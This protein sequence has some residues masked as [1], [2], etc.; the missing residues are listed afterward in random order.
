MR[1]RRELADDTRETMA[2]G[3][4]Y[5]PQLRQLVVDAG[6]PAGLA[7]LPAVESGFEPRARGRHGELGLWQL[8]P[9][10]AR[11]FGL[12]VNS[13]RDDR[14]DP[15]RSTRAAVR[16]LRFLTPTCLSYGSP[17]TS[18][19]LA[20]V[21]ELLAAVREEMPEGKIY[22]GTF[23]SECRPEHVTRESLRVL[24]KY[25][26][27]RTLVIGGQ[28]GSERTL[29]ET[30]RGHGVAEII[31]AVRLSVEAGF[32]PN[33][34]LLLG[35]PGE[36]AEDR[37]LSLQLARK[38][39]GL[40]ARIHSHAFMPLPGTPLRGATPAEIEPA[41]LREMERMESAG[42]MYGQWRR[43][44]QVAQQLVTLRAAPR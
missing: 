1:T 8:R 31:E 29:R 18:V 37:A 2:R 36:T 9:A 30:H 38:L 42:A 22:F 27:N 12:V 35:L 13:Q 39:I 5:L 15:A 17:D 4:P 34:D 3:A 23:P 10:T 33:V 16:Y 32:L 7:L 25:L 24:K 41:T 21:E 44:V 20:A 26:D 19:N 28:S 14:T 43:H 6:L 11:R 40:G